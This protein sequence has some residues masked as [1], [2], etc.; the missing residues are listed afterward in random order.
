MG[1]IFNK[2]QLLSL[3]KIMETYELSDESEWYFPL[4][5]DRDYFCELMI[6]LLPGSNSK[7]SAVFIKRI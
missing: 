3:I 1:L 4:D 6:P 5:N 7:N 2:K